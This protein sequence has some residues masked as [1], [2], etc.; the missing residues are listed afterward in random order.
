[1]AVTF[2]FFVGFNWDRD[3]RDRHQSAISIS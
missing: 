3:L 2:Y 1:M